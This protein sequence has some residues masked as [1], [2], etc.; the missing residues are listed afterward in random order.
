MSKK[1][2][3]VCDDQKAR[4]I[5]LLRQGEMICSY[6][7]AQIRNPDCE[8][9]D[10][11]EQARAYQ[12][13]KTN[14]AGSKHFFAEIDEQVED[15]VD[16]ALA[17]V[18]AGDVEEAHQEMLRLKKDNPKNYMVSYGLGVVHAFKEELDE[19]IQCFDEATNIFPYFLEAHFNKAIA[20]KKKFDIGNMVKAFREVVALG[21]HDDEKVLEAKICLRDLEK[22]CLQTD[23]VNLDTY[24]EG[25]KIFE[26][27]FDCMRSREWEK[28]ID[29]FKKCLSKNKKHTQSYGNLGICCAQLGKRKEALEAL[30]K[31]LEIDPNYGPAINNRILV[32]ALVE[33]EKLESV[34]MNE[35]EYYKELYFRKKEGTKNL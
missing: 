15:A 4:R 14:P 17:L 25:M 8:G 27:A 34:Q 10:Y 18:E 29:G 11:Y 24:L 5:C 20:Y 9:C 2:C 35:E 19:A 33:G 16:E 1:K 28:A 6:C 21:R 7:C 3:V 12:L 32:E 23:G 13:T 30:D 26:H 31:A 22:Q